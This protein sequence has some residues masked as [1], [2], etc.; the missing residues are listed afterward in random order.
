MAITDREMFRQTSIISPDVTVIGESGG[1]VRP[2]KVLM[3]LLLEKVE[4][5]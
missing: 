5:E 1:G 4:V 2:Q 3:L